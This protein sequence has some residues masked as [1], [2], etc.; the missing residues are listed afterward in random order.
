[1]AITTWARSRNY[2]DA[3]QKYVLLSYLNDEI[4]SFNSLSG[5][6]SDYQ[7]KYPMQTVVGVDSIRLQQTS[8]AVEFPAITLYE[9]G[10]RNDVSSIVDSQDDLISYELVAAVASDAGDIAWAAT[11]A[12]YMALC[13]MTVMERN[14]P[15]SPGQTTKVCAVYR[16]DP[17]STAQSRTV[18]IKSGKLYMS[19]YAVRFDVYSR[20]LIN[21]S[22][23]LMPD[24]LVIDPW[25]DSVFDP[26]DKTPSIE[27]D[28]AV[29]LSA[30]ADANR[31]TNV[32]LTAAQLAGATTIDFD[33]STFN[34]TPAAYEVFA[35]NQNTFET[36][37]T[38]ILTDTFSIPISS[39][40]IALGDLWIVTV[41]SS[42]FNTPLT[43]PLSWSITP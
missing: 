37:T 33:L 12:K 1:M 23:S 9:V 31:S 27:T 19:A 28:T 7:V 14:L 38:N 36:W 34:Q 32:T 17:V 13:A 40:S 21:Y 4:D 3:K 5:L 8:N 42:V 39:V 6:G 18:P 16:V 10:S 26:I 30:A 20:V 15:D 43:Y 24:T 41:K 22:P 29:S 25:I 35:V 2:I 11:M